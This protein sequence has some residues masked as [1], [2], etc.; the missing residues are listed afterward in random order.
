MKDNRKKLA[1]FAALLSVCIM[2][3]GCSSSDTGTET[4][5]ADVSSVSSENASSEEADADSSGTAE[6]G[7]ESQSIN[8]DPP[9]NTDDSAA[10][11]GSVRGGRKDAFGGELPDDTNGQLP[12]GGRNGNSGST[13]APTPA[14][15]SVNTPLSTAGAGKLDTSDLFSSR[16]QNQ[17]AD[18]SDAETLTVSDGKTIEITE[19]GIYIIKGTASDC[20]IKVNASNDAKVQ[21][22]LDNVTVENS[23]F[24]AIYVVSADKCFVTSASGSSN[25]LSVTGTFKS[26]G[27]TNTDAVIFSK[28]DLVLNGSGALKITS[29][30]GNGISGKD[31]LKITGGSYEITSAQDAVEANDSI[32]ISGGSFRITSSKDGFHA[33]NDEDST[34]GWVYISDGSFEITSKSDGIQATTVLQIDG[35]TFSISAAEGLEATYIQINGGDITIKSSDDGVNAST[36]SNL[37]TPCFEMTNGTLDITVS[38]SDV[39]AVDANGNVTVSGGSIN[40]TCP[41][42]GMNESFDYDGTAA[43]T[44]GTITVNGQQLDSIPTAKMMGGGR[45][46]MGGMDGQENFGGRG[47]MRGQ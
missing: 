20:T 19:E 2:T 5:K 30:N 17:T 45:G 16:D 12:W 33:E 11:D 31:D 47:R 4:V 28:D 37:I 44:G 40:I 32:R 14:D 42:Q 21:L 7:R 29:A 26:D 1:V 38:G 41:T 27:D 18:T 15:G 35:G 3:A 39:D 36:K 6:K 25:S 22:V 24:P 10:A 46:N 9:E 13:I 8:I 43:F 23:D 34:S